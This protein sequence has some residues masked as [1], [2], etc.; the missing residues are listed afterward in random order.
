M[1]C[2][3]DIGNEDFEKNGDAVLTPLS[4]TSH[5]VAG[6][7]YDM[8]M[9]H[10]IDPDGKWRH[11][12]PG[13]IVKIPVPEEVIENSFSGYD[14]D[15][16]KTTAEAELREQANAP[17]AITYPEWNGS[18]MSP[19][20]YSVGDKVSVTGAGHRNYQCVY[21]DTSSQIR[22][23]PPYNSS[24][25]KEIPDSTT[26]APVLVTLPAGTELYFVEDVNT[27]WYKMSTYYGLEG[28]IQKSKVTFDRHVSA[29][30]NQPR[31]IKEQLF[32]L[33]EP[34]IDND[35]QTV[36]VNGKH[37][38]YDLNGDL[39]QSV[40][41]SQASPAMALG[42]ILEGL[43][44]PYRGTIATNLTTDA[45]GTYTGEIKGKNGMYAL[46]DPDKGIV[47]AFNARFTRDNWDL[48]VMQRTS[49]DRGYR[50][51]YG[52][53]ARG[54]KWKRSSTNL[55]N[56]IVPVAKDESG[57]DLY[58][59]EKWVDSPTISSYPV[60]IMERLAVAGQIGKDKGIGDGSVWDA[61]DLY[62]EMRT[63]A[64][65]RFSV[66]H[67]DEIAEEV[68][69]QI[70]QL[71]NTAEY[72]WLKGLKNVLLYDTVKA[73]D[74]RI[75]LAMTLYVSELEYDFVKEKVAGLKLS[76]IQDFGGR[77]VT[78]YNVQNNSIGSE[79]LTDIAK[80]ELV[81]QAVDIM[82][83]YANPGSGTGAK[84]NT[85][86]DDGYVLKGG[87]NYG[88]VW[89]TDS[90]GTPAWRDEKSDQVPEECSVT[91]ASQ[92]NYV[93]ENIAGYNKVVRCGEIVHVSFA[94]DCSTP[95][96][97][98]PGIKFI[99]AGMPKPFL[100]QL[101]ISIPV[102]ANF[103]DGQDVRVTIDNSGNMYLRHGTTSRAYD[104]NFTYIADINT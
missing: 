28:Y 87:T 89:K 30:E 45:N 96:T 52:V 67:A 81:Q 68:T 53:N 32:R 17:T 95:Y 50:I 61:T 74:E 21:F 66:Q 57:G 73:Y 100:G 80:Q 88:K 19:T 24:W 35:A 54:I 79:K 64:G 63:K 103:A 2:V 41:I 16:Y 43:M 55:V 8:Q 1:I 34:T 58:L 3:Y 71:E 37:V 27:T 93:L 104:I 48:F 6:G 9:V 46:L 99:S 75:G 51:R 82:P 40:A 86:T 78:G 31:V 36:T 18:Q 29:S 25:W 101:Y 33:K 90:N 39:V 15:I 72:E 94:V 91:F 62:N 69:I 14:A 92:N 98:Y 49:V 77:T 70:E 10:P 85:A 84:P 26:G 12:V 97:T 56:R 13:A 5:N 65:E 60:I 20:E 76:N 38:S 7:N 59:P 23:V 44:I 42:R 4:G 47:S 102:N 11:L 22:Y 83:E